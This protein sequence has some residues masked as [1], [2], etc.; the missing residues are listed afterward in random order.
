MHKSRPDYSKNQKKHGKRYF[1]PTHKP[2]EIKKKTLTFQYGWYDS[3]RTT[4]E[5]NSGQKTVR[6]KI[7]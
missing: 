2:T 6:Q 5:L 7:L 4:E 3:L 1:W